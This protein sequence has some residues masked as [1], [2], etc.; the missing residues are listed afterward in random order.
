MNQIITDHIATIF[1]DGSKYFDVFHHYS[2]KDYSTKD[3]CIIIQDYNEDIYIRKNQTIR[4]SLKDIMCL[5]NHIIYIQNP[6]SLDTHWLD[7]S[8]TKI[9]VTIEE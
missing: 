4:E 9:F 3:Y 5:T 1:V 8:Y 2:T 7:I 6:I